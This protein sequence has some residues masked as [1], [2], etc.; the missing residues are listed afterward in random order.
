MVVER[1]VKKVFISKLKI[2]LSISDYVGISNRQDVIKSSS[3]RIQGFFIN[4][5]LNK[6]YAVFMFN[7]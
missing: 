3:L 7:N 2:Y 5:K 6:G 1:I 4:D